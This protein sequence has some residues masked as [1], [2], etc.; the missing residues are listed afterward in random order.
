MDCI[1]IL[2]AD[3][4]RL[5][6]QGLVG[7]LGSEPGFE[8]VGEA[9]SKAETLRLLEATRPDVALLD[10]AMPGV[11]GT[12]LIEQVL[13]ID[14]AP[15]VIVL[16]ASENP[17]DL[18]GALRAGARGYFLKN[19]DATSLFAAIRKVY[20]GGI[21][22]GDTAMPQVVELLRGIPVRPA[23]GQVLTLREQEVLALVADGLDNS[24]IG[25]RL[26]IS[27]HTVKTHVA[28]ILEKLGVHSRAELVAAGRP[29]TIV[30]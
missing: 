19:I 8:V 24:A 9:A 28:H 6:R 5:F 27:E 7:L 16:T 15:R 10:L 26:V 11:V 18:A 20:A 14:P 23:P 13:M 29:R 30:Q 25:A 17:A 12:E 3:D 22:V 4:H 21:A 1:R 2:I